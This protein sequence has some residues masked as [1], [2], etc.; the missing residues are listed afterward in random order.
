M[1]V[2]KKVIQVYKLY[3]TN[4]SLLLQKTVNKKTKPVYY[5]PNAL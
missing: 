3:I 5:K 2:S 1:T 4:L